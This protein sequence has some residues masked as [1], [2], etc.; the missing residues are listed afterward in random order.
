MARSVLVTG[1]AGFVGSHVVDDLLRAGYHVRALDLLVDQVHPRGQRPEYLS[2]EVELAVADV[3]DRAALGRALGGVDAVVHLAAR[4]S[5][6]QSMYE[7][8]AYAA[9]N[10][11][12]TAIL[13][14]AL[15]DRGIGR[16]VVASSM[17]IYGEGLYRRPDGSVVV[18][19]ART[20]EQ[21]QRGEWEPSAEL[22]PLPTPEWKPPSLSSV[23]ELIGAARVGDIRHCFADVSLARELL[24][25]EPQVA[26]EDGLAELVEWLEGRAAEDRFTAAADE[27]HRRGLTL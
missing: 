5:V 14:E 26:L 10:T 6:G 18:D 27:L 25:F 2:D 21:L 23:P 9:V 17:S 24:G 4:V 16:L 13:L 19:A 22:E 3:R 7:L 8:A 20:R 1:G 15:L 11:T 12:G